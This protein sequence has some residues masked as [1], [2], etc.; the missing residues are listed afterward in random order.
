VGMKKSTLHYYDKKDVF[1]PSTHGIEFE[2]NY[3]LYDP[4]QITTIKMI[5][6]LR[7][8]GISLNTIKEL[9]EN[10]TPEKLIKL[11]TSS[12]DKVLDEINFLQETFSVV[13]V[14]LDNLVEGM[15]VTESEITVSEKLEKSIILGGENDFTGTTA[16]YREFTRFCNAA[17]E[18]KI[19]ASYPI[20]AY[21]SSIDAF[22]DAPSLPMRFYSADPKGSDKKAAGLYLTGYTRGYYGHVNDLPERMSAFAKKHDLVFTGSVYGTCL[23]DEL[24]IVDPEQYLFQ[25]SAAVMETRRV[26]ARRPYRHLKS[27]V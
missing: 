6:V 25:V 2:N 4:T 15:S 20:G 23:F 19:N 11:L 22:M 17:H 3:R 13:R 18:P 7:E 8:I 14:F 10:R 1:H 9:K 5:R 16:F 26:T 12:K 24:S 21:W 27:K